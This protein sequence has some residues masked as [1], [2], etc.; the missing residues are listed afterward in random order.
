MLHEEIQQADFVGGQFGELRDDVLSYEVGAA[1]GWGQ[2]EG[3]LEP[4]HA[5]AA[6]G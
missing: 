6:A 2:G 3:F 4:G 5:A 1:R